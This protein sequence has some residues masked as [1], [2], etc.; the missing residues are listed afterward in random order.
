MIRKQFP[1]LL[2]E[3]S[4]GVELGV[5]KGEFSKIILNNWDGT[6]YMIDVWRS[7]PTDEYSDI[8]NQQNP[9][10][11]YSEA[12]SN[13]LGYEDRAF[14]LRIPGKKAVNLFNDHSLDF[15]YIDANHTYESVKQDIELW[16][17]KVRIGGLIGGHDYLPRHL[18]QKDKNIPIYFDNGVY[19]GMFGVNGAVDE[20]TKVY[21][22]ELNTTNEF[23]GTWWTIK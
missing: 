14:M 16:Y 6:L 20:F 15:I 21:N 8:S 18:F 10:E 12:I 2:N 23:F 5:Y 19:A 3:Y 1:T 9:I 4:I 7:L 11:V 22:L 17:P 13:I